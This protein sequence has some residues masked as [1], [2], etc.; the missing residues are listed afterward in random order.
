MMGAFLLAIHSLLLVKFMNDVSGS[1]TIRNLQKKLVLKDA[2]WQGGI[3]LGFT[4]HG[5]GILRFRLD[6]I[7]FNKYSELH[8]VSVPHVGFSDHWLVMA[9]YSFKDCANFDK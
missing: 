8:N 6:H 1:Y 4:C 2:W 9:D 5:Y 7:L 3:G